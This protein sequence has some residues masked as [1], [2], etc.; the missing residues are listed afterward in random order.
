MNYKDKYNIEKPYLKYAILKKLYTLHPITQR[1]F[2]K[3]INQF[4][5][6]QFYSLTLRRIFKEMYDIEVGMGSYGCFTTNFRPHMKVGNYCC[7]APGVQRLV[8]NHPMENASMHP[9]FYDPS[10]GCIKESRYTHHKLIVG[11]GVWVGVNA[12]I[13]G[14]CEEI[15]DGAV[16]GAGSVVTHNV[17]AYAVVAGSPARIIKYRLTEDEREL[18]TNS[19]WWKYTP[20]QL[21]EAIIN[22]KGIECFCKDINAL[23]NGKK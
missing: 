3:Y 20:E 23:K 18:L 21:K 14:N 10:F 2:L 19:N 17:P 22:Y 5:G 15:G 6:G 11:H 16:I 4:E 13:T 7:F 9:I 12:I 8:G 1:L